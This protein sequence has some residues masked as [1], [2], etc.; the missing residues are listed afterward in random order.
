MLGKFRIYLVAFFFTIQVLAA[1]NRRAKML[2]G[3][4][5]AEIAAGYSLAP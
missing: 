3:E 5:A 2:K 4:T 1:K